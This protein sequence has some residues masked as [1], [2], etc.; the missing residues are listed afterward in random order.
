MAKM[1]GNDYFR[2]CYNK[3][4]E[5]L[6]EKCVVNLMVATGHY[7]NLK[8]ITDKTE[9][10]EELTIDEKRRAKAMMNAVKFL[11]RLA[12][13]SF[14]AGLHQAIGVKMIHQTVL[15]KDEEMDEMID[16]EKDTFYKALRKRLLCE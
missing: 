5:E 8:T 4:Q 11:D 6:A 3:I 13:L 2:Q 15:V 10:N 14:V 9:R 12:A 7:E 1:K 16:T